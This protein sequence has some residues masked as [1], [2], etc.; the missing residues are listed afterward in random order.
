MPDPIRYKD[1]TEIFI[2]ARM[3]DTDKDF[4]FYLRGSKNLIEGLNA[5]GQLEQMIKSDLSKISVTPVSGIYYNS[6][7]FNFEDQ[8]ALRD[9]DY[10]NTLIEVHLPYCLH[11]PNNYELE[12]DMDNK[13]KKALVILNKIWTNKAMTKDGNSDLVDIYSEDDVVYLKNSTILTPVLP[14]KPEEGWEQNFTGTNIEK[15]KEQN[16]VF[17][18][19][20]LFIQFDTQIDL[21]K[22]DKED[23][24][25]TL[26]DVNDC[27]LDIVNK[28]IDVYR[29][30]TKQEHIQRLGSLGV[31]MIYFI[32]QKVGFYTLSPGFGI[33]T[34]SLNR[35]KKEIEQIARMLELGEKPSLYNL[36][37]LDAQS[38]FDNKR[39]ALAVVQSFQ[40]LEIFIEDYILKLLKQRGDTEQQCNDYLDKNWKTKDRLKEVLK[41]LKNTTL[42]EGDRQLWDKWCKIYNNTR[43]E[44]IHQGKEAREGEVKDV[45]ET[46]RKVIEWLQK[47]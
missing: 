5:S 37:I 2:N 18:Y 9:F 45:L 8:N 38:S 10:G 31:N 24:K 4:R 25:E 42:F 34:A 35:S 19:S 46:N 32:N 20:R 41:D 11:F 13:E 28:L 1:Q 29:F 22:L 44:I 23:L 14:I 39:Y 26:K 36:L 17:R 30:I 40:A 6:L 16:G 15:I 43:N 27:A 12:I 3:P 33:E 7:Q 47:I 21:T